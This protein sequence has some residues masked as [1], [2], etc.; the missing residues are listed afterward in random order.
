MPQATLFHCVLRKSTTTNQHIT[1][2][3]RELNKL[4]GTQALMRLKMQRQQEAEAKAETQALQA[5]FKR[6]M[7]PATQ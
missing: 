4:N 6:M 2:W 5:T 3:A 1:Y 7:L